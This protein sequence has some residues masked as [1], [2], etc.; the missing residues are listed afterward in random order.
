MDSIKDDKVDLNEIDK[1][2]GCPESS[3]RF[4]GILFLDIK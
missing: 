3:E 1:L 2:L 4:Y